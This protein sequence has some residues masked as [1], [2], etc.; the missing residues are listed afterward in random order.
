MPPKKKQ[1]VT[2]IQQKILIEDFYNEIDDNDEEDFPDCPRA[3]FEDSDSEYEP[4]D[5]S[6]DKNNDCHE[7]DLGDIEMEQDVNNIL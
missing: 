7:N 4:G 2:E 3:A 6:N 5:Y 1:L